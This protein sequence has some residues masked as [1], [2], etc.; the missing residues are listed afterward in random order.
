LLPR[1]DRRA[2]GDEGVSTILIRRNKQTCSNGSKSDE[3]AAGVDDLKL[4]PRAGGR[5]IGDEWRPRAA[6]LVRGY[7]KTVCGRAYPDGLAHGRHG[8]RGES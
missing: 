6:V 1:S 8:V 7:E 4:F 2:I 5:A 3:S